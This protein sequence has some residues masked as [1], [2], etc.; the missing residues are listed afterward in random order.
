MSSISTLNDEQVDKQSHKAKE[1]ETLNR[2]EKAILTLIGDVQ[3]DI[4]LSEKVTVQG[5]TPRGHNKDA[6]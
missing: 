4:D 5:R 3:Y 2:E 6:T 1:A